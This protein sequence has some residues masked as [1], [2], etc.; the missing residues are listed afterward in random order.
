MRFGDNNN[1][2]ELEEYL[3]KFK[4]NQNMNESDLFV[5]GQD[6]GDGSPNNHFHIGFTSKKPLKL[7]AKFGNRGCWHIDAT[8][9]IIKYCY[10]L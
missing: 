2:N 3:E 10:P 4:F 7:I 6:L 1:I 5:F 9:K 8:Y